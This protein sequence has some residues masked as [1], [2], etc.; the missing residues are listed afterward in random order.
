[1]NSNFDFKYIDFQT[2]VQTWELDKLKKSY[3]LP[4][5]LIANV[6][7]ID[8]LE[9]VGNPKAGLWKSERNP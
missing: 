9:I 3:Y 5:L 2:K 4:V 6:S 1:M 8:G 7:E